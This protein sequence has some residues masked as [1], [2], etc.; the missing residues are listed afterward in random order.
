MNLIETIHRGKLALK[1]LLN[2][3]L[4]ENSMY[5]Y[6]ECLCF[7]WISNHFLSVFFQLISLLPDKIEWPLHQCVGKD[8]LPNLITV[9]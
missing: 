8:C 9:Y 3:R 5:Q 2:I 4:T 7:L 6:F 1:Q